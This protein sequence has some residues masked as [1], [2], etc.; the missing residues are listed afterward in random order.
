M[1][2][3][4]LSYTRSDGNTGASRAAPLGVFAV[5][6]ASVS[7]T[8]ARP[9]SATTKNQAL[10][11]FGHGELAEFGTHIMNASRKPVV[12]CK[13]DASIDGTYGAI[14]VEGDPDSGA[15]AIT[16]GVTK[17]IDRFRVVVKFTTAGT[18]GT[19]GIKYRVS[20][21]GGK[22]FGPETALGTDTSI[23]I[24]DT[25]ITL[26]LAAGTVAAG[27]TV[28]FTTTGPTATLEDLLP[29]L[30]ALRLTGLTYEAILIGS[31]EADAEMINGVRTAVE[32]F[33]ARGLSKRVMINVRPF[34]VDD[35]DAQDY[36][37][38]LAVIS[39]A[40]RI[41]ERVDVC[42]DGGYLPSPIRGVSMWRPA[43][44]AL[45]ARVAKISAGTD[46]AYVA[47]GPVDGFSII[48]SDGAAVAWD[49]S[50]TPGL[51]DLG[52]VTL[53]TFARRSGCF[54]GNPRVFSPEGS[55]FVFDQQ[56]RCMC[57]AEERSFDFLTEELS[58]RKRKDP[59][60]GPSG[61]VYLLESDV[62]ELESRGTLDLRA[63]LRGEVD[64]VRLR[65]SRVDDVGANSGAVVTATVEISS[66]VYIKGFAVTTRFVRSFNV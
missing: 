48:D 14:T 51:D 43:S 12:L 46:A 35:E 44:L 40:A 56:E 22:T 27:E 26:A 19:D 10:S 55:D 53:T 50:A 39:A 5:I 57:V 59:K 9:T 29:C 41:G 52:F 62:A 24:P 1:A 21:N 18:R 58:G 6:A 32:A 61:E 11:G 63:Q 30:E 8:A 49:E 28:S 37:D 60:L 36:I 47:D 31:V 16:A 42:A 64:D 15:S 66:L 20:L 3:P 33:M 54:I 23:E 65:L 45:A 17:P 7:G 4:S 2:L 13:V 34:A 38:D 25:G